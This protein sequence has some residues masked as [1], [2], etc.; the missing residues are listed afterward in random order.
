[1]FFGKLVNIIVVENFLSFLE[2]TRTLNSEVV[3][4]LYAQNTKLGRN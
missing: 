3:C 1:M 4:E 2:I